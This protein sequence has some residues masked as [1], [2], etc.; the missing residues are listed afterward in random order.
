MVNSYNRLEAIS[1]LVIL[2]WV[3]LVQGSCGSCPAGT[4]WNGTDCGKNKN[5]ACIP[6]PP[7]SFSSTA[8]EQRTCNIC[9]RCEGIFRTKRECTPTSNTECD[10]MSGY[11]CSGVGCNRCQ[12]DCKQGQ[13]LLGKGCRDC[14]FGTFNDQ[15][16]GNCKRW[17]NCSLNGLVVLVNG[18]NKRDVICGS[19]QTVA[20]LDTISMTIPASLVHIDKNHQLTAFTLAVI[21]ASGLFA[22]LILSW[23]YCSMGNKKKLPYFLKQAFIKPVQTAQE[24]DACSCGFPE[25][26]QG[27]REIIKFQS[28]LHLELFLKDS[29]Q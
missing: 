21:M 9:R 1:T 4:F 5:Q 18:T 29:K 26:E 17:T 13:E 28:E 3:T 24:E 10:C 2:L 19:T 20:T 14:S 6:C 8:G 27:E 15:T 22:L 23:F 7:N 12:P 11:H 25:E 16:R